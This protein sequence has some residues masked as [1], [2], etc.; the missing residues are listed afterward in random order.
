MRIF[1]TGASGFV[2]GHVVEGLEADHEVLAMARS[3]RSQAAVEA[4]GARA[5]RCNLG[6]IEASHLQGVDA[7]IHCAARVEDY[8]PRE[9]FWEANVEGTQ[10]MLDASRTA[11]VRRFVH[12]G[13]EA[14]VFDGHDLVDI[15]E[16]HPYPRR[17]RFLYSETKAEAERRVL[18]ASDQTMTALS[19]RPRLIW[20]PRDNSV[21]PALVDT[22]ERGAFAWIDGGRPR[23]STVHVANLV[24][25][26]EL[27]LTR[28]RGGEAYFV[29]DGEDSTYRE[30]LGRLVAT[31][32]ARV[33]E[34]S[35]PGALLRPVAWLVERSW[36]L[37]R[38]SARPPLSRFAVAMMSSTVTIDIS[39]AREEL[40]Y[41]PV[42]GVDEGLRQLADARAEPGSPP[43][44]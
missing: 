10:R 20:G 4:F 35:V 33:P 31:T 43:R 41:A 39:K 29:T 27:A 19:L 36:G 28:G 3:D 44:K 23:T 7:V 14:A 9:A 42:I 32:G 17:H 5:V 18:A 2:G 37:L 25:A 13:T 26:L 24:H 1:V 11:G 12:I 30:F 16:R 34:R 40:G 22:I 38:P 21:L 6:T 8:G 15:D